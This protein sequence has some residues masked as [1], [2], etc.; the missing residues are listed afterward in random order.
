MKLFPCATMKGLN[1]FHFCNIDIRVHF[2]FIGR[3]QV[4]VR[5]EDITKKETGSIEATSLTSE[6]AKL[7]GNV[8][9]LLEA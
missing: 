9:S 2:I 3:R 7:G 6:E 5:E 8:R 4:A 1:I